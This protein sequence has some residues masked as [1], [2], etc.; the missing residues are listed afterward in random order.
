LETAIQAAV[1]DHWRV[2]GLP[3]TLVA[4]IPNA[5]AHGQPGL[6]K[7][8]ADLLVIGPDLP[9]IG[10]AG[11]IELKR[12]PYSKR[13]DAQWK[14]A[15]LTLALGIP[16]AVTFGRDQPIRILEAWGVVRRPAA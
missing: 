15:E 16:Y 13:T 10:S 3:N 1:V 12:D 7:G 4:A 9:G 14:F 5:N 6:T 2:L 8:L 11:F